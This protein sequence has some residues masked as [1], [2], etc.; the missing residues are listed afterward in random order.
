VVYAT[1]NITDPHVF[2][3]ATPSSQSSHPGGMI[4]NT[5]ISDKKHHDPKQKMT[6]THSPR[7]PTRA[8]LPGTGPENHPF[9]PGGCGLPGIP[10]GNRTTPEEKDRSISA[11]H[12]KRKELLK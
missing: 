10:V 7:T 5:T 6:P 11:G 4:A 1:A 3:I 8:A 12:M 2:S 9:T